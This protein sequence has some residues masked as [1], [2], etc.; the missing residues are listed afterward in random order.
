MTST[1][2]QK[3]GKLRI[4]PKPNEGTQTSSL[5]KVTCDWCRVKFIGTDL[6]KDH[7]AHTYRGFHTIRCKTRGHRS[8]LI[9]HRRCGRKPE[10]VVEGQCEACLFF[11]M[12]RIPLTAS[13]PE[14]VPGSYGSDATTIVPVLSSHPR[15]KGPQTSVTGSS[16]TYA[17]ALSSIASY[18]TAP[19]NS[20][21]M[22]RFGV[23]RRKLN[24]ALYTSAQATMPDYTDEEF[25]DL[26]VETVFQDAVTAAAM[27]VWYMHRSEHECRSLISC[28]LRSLKELTLPASAD[29]IKPLERVVDTTVLDMQQFSTRAGFAVHSRWASLKDTIRL[30]VFEFASV[31]PHLQDQV[32]R[33]YWEGGQVFTSEWLNYLHRRGIVVDPD[34]EL[35]WSGRGQHVEYQPG[36]EGIIPLK[37]S[38]L[39]GE[40][41]SAIVDSVMCRRIELARKIIWCSRN[42]TKEEAVEE[43]KSL[44]QALHRHV[45]RVVGTYLFKR[46][47]IQELAILLY[48]AAQW[49]LE[50]YMDSLFQNEPHIHGFASANLSTFVGCLSHALQFIHSKHV[51]HMDIKPQNLLVRQAGFEYRIYVADFGIARTYRCDEESN[52]DSPTS[53]TRIYA[54]PEVV[55][56]DTRGYSADI[57]SLGC[58]FMEILATL[59]TTIQRNERKL[60]A[61]A[62]RSP[63]DKSYQGNLEAVRIWHRNVLERLDSLGDTFGKERWEF[64]LNGWTEPGTML[65]SEPDGRPNAE[66]LKGITANHTCGQCDAGPEPFEAA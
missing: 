66:I 42:L 35:N 40:S 63:G 44:Q 36:E 13:A 28:S 43:V 62:H 26:F 50:E 59:S 23:A 64:M 16:R 14:E 6:L 2:D 51:K 60:L 18:T 12:A 3:T 24:P 19:A 32:P 34:A 8:I 61:E 55:A 54:A 58:V 4:Q 37:S 49:N 27:P 30:R 20:A 53:F 15:P 52:T 38:R 22:W 25:F 29:S 1:E 46:G 10:T 48:P 45:V 9:R 65:A 33:S 57:F 56:Q 41:N 31:Q 39:L 5:S 21:R 47:H 11:P 7:K 17:S